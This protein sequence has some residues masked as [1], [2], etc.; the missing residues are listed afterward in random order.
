M[1]RQKAFLWTLDQSALQLKFNTTYTC[2]FDPNLFL[3]IFLPTS[4]YTWPKYI[5][6]SSTKEIVEKTQLN[7]TDKISASYLS[8]QVA[9]VSLPK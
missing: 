7:L 1:L 5:V 4:I 3:I 8:L 6:F 9:S 2:E